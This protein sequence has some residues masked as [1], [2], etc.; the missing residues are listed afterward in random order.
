[1]EEQRVV[2]IKKCRHL[3]AIEDAK[4]MGVSQELPKIVSTLMKEVTNSKKNQPY[5]DSNLYAIAYGYKKPYP[6]L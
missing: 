6:N 1:M 2:K 5:I 3:T 4:K